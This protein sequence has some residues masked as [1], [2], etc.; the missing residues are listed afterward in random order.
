[1]SLFINICQS[2]SSLR[3]WF[4]SLLR[5]SLDEV[6]FFWKTTQPQPTRLPAPLSW[7]LCLLSQ[8]GCLALLALFPHRS[9]L[10][11]SFQQQFCANGCLS[12]LC[13]LTNPWPANRPS[14]FLV[15]LVWV[16]SISSQLTSQNILPEGWSTLYF[17][18]YSCFSTS[19]QRR[20]HNALQV[21][22]L[23][24]IISK[25]IHS[26]CISSK[27]FVSMEIMP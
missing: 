2:P 26:Y 25:L 3:L 15:A 4:Y 16:H 5:F 6:F 13:P 18:S 9:I 7:C 19:V 1:M 14:L 21:P 12:M 23:F 10:I 27:Y 8:E 24:K 17:T 20:Q 11:W 22:C